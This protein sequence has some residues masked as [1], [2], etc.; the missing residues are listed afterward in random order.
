[1]LYRDSK[2]AYFS[3]SLIGAGETRWQV[4]VVGVPVKEFDAAKKAADDQYPNHSIRKRMQVLLDLV[5]YYGQN[6][7]VH[8]TYRSVCAGD[9]IVVH[10]DDNQDVAYWLITSRG[11]IDMCEAEY[12]KYR[13]LSPLERLKHRLELS[14]PELDDVRE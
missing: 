11:F 8:S 7:V 5:Y 13:E 4:V 10:N 6:E 14:S 1:M 9:V 3:V 2:Y 12:L